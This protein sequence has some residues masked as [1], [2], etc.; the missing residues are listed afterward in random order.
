MGRKEK[1]KLKE[2]AFLNRIYDLILDK[3]TT[4]DERIE[5][6]KFK[7]EVEKGKDFESE[8][9][10]LAESLRFLALSKFNKDKQNL[11]KGVGK[12]YMDISST[13]FLKAE[14]GIGMIVLSGVLGNH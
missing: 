1:I 5:L 13:G 14:L 10:R 6:I 3:E 9:M 4:E 2:E 12:L 11:S 8:T 7:N